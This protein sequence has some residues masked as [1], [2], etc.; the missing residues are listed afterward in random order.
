LPTL[1]KAKDISLFC[2][3]Y[4]ALSL[5]Q[6]NNL[7]ADLF[8]ATSYYESAYDPK[9]NSVDVGSQNDPNTWSVGLL[10]LS[11]VDQESYSLPFGYSFLDLQD[12]IKNLQLGVAIMAAQ[13]KK[14]GTVLIGVGSP[15]LYWATLH[16]GGKYD[17]SAEIESKTKGL[18]FCTAKL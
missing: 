5:D 7:W 12:P 1:D 6:K 15:G 11:V 18:S 16:P 10:Q 9:S 4:S 17:A 8:A 2:P 3:N 14:Y 13:I